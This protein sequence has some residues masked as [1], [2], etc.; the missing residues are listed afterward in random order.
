MLFRSRVPTRKIELTK[1]ER[2]ELR[3]AEVDL[4]R[5]LTPQKVG[6]RIDSASMSGD[7]ES[8]TADYPL[9]ETDLEKY[10]EPRQ[11]SRTVSSLD[12]AAPPRSNSWV[13][14]RTPTNKLDDIAVQVEASIE[15]D[16]DLLVRVFEEFG[17][18][19]HQGS[20]VDDVLEFA[21]GRAVELVPSDAGWLLLADLGRRDLYFAAAV[22][23]KAR[24]VIDYRLPF[25]KGIAG[26][27]ATNGV[28]L[29]LSDVDQDPRFQSAISR[30][31]GLAVQSVACAPI[32]HEGRVYGA[33]QV[34]NHKHRGEY[35]TTE[36]DAGSY[37]ARRVA[38][39]L[40]ARDA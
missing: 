32:Q 15:D 16:S 27:C 18:I 9:S 30:Q 26:F 4:Q 12:L 28:S 2:E 38:E 5:S 37:I 14:S 39:F 19:E 13:V 3:G 17:E 1:A 40:A 10:F 23:A 33:L 24:E 36:L 7:V 8:S 22:G 31:V 34:M 11:V 35:T 20:A 21:L 6:R 25:G 29:T